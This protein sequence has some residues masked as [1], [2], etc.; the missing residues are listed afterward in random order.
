M[1]PDGPLLLYVHD[2]MCSWCWGYRPTWQRLKAQLPPGLARANLLGGLAP[3][4]EVPMAEPMRQQL[5]GIWQRIQATLGTEFNFEF[6][7]RCQPRRS[8]YPACR[9]VLAA[10]E[11]G[12]EEA[13]I[14]ALQ[15]AYYLDAQNPSDQDTHKSLA[16]TLGLDRA[17]FDR[18][19]TAPGTEQALQAQVQLARQLPIQ[20]FPSLVLWH[21]GW[22]PL[23]LDYRDPAPTL[24]AIQTLL[25]T[26][27]NA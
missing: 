8:T 23:P 13:M 3:D 15:R 25:A 26:P 21:Q 4:S 5:Q 7:Q 18:A 9:A 17:R 22:H 2:P 12:A 16:D 14:L 27:A 10:A 19:L 20:G 6:W 1:R 24:A 11:Q